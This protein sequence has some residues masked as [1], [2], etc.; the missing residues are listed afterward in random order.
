MRQWLS[1]DVCME[2]CVLVCAHWN[3]QNTC[4]GVEKRASWLYSFNTPLL[5]ECDAEALQVSVRVVVLFASRT[6]NPKATRHGTTAIKLAYKR[7]KLCL[8]TVYTRLASQC[9]HE[10]QQRD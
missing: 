7:T 10:Q 2:C 1:L 6:P 4:M 8:C 9:I 5:C 3:C